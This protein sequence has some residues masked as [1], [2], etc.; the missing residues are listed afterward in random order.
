M[1]Y[2]PDEF[3]GEMNQ[4]NRAAGAGNPED[5]GGITAFYLN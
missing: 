5:P 2:D 1:T 4:S 3:Q